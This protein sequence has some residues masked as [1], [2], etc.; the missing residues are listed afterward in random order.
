[1]SSQSAVRQVLPQGNE[2]K[3][4]NQR[5]TNRG[6]NP[7]PTRKGDKG[8]TPKGGTDVSGWNDD[9]PTATR[10]AR[11]A[12]LILVDLNLADGSSR[13]DASC[14]E[15]RQQKVGKRLSR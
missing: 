3:G 13:R 1:M 10:V 6:T 9:N 2:Q 15:E 7:G 11:D 5:G 12:S 4:N 14:V 8:P